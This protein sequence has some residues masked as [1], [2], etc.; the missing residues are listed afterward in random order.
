MLS[1]GTVDRRPRVLGEGIAVRLCVDLGRTIDHR[2]ADGADGARFLDT[3]V[4]LLEH[5]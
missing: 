5:R 2:V 1:V 3:L 4:E